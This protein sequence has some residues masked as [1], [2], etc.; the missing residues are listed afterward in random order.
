ME[1]IQLQRIQARA[2]V[3]LMERR[4]EPP[5][6]QK[7]GP[8]FSEGWDI[9]VITLFKWEGKTCGITG[10]GAVQERFQQE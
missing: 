4:I 5:H 10:K 7:R 6:R 3:R 9:H 1:Q 8:G 2:V